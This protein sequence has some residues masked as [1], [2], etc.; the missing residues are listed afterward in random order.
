MSYARLIWGAIA[1]IWQGL[2]A[3][4]ALLGFLLFSTKP[5][6]GVITA[7][8][9]AISTVLVKQAILLLLP[10]STSHGSARFADYEDLV[11]AKLFA[12]K[13]II[14]GRKRGRMIRYKG[15]GHLLTFAPTRSGKGVGCV[16]PNLLS[17]SGSVVVTDIKGENIAIAGR[18]RES[19]GQVYELA[20]FKEAYNP[21][22]YN[23]FDFIRVGSSYEVDD[24][25][26]ISE[27]LVISERAE[28]NHWEREARTLITGLILYIMHEGNVLTQ[29]PSR[30]RE[31][32]M[33]DEEGFEL[34]IATMMAHEHPVISRIA[35]GFSQKAEKERSGVVS[36]AQGATE[37][38]E[39]PLLSKITSNSSFCLSELKEKTV[40]LFLV[41]P[42]EYLDTYRPYLRLMIGLCAATMTR[43]TTRPEHEV[44]FLLDELPAL[45]YMRPIEEGIGYLAGYKAK[46]WL[47]VQDLDQLQHTYP[48]A[49]SII[50]NCAVRQAFNV[51]DPQTARLLSEMM[52][53]TTIKLKSAGSTGKL[54]I[55]LM[56]GSYQS[57]IHEGSRE[58]M[59]P[60]EVMAMNKKLQLLFIQGIPPIKAKKIRY[61]DWSEWRFW[62]KY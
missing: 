27:M 47:F 54:P 59:T 48:K 23:P 56:S 41:I 32:L 30:L 34:Y 60:A 35:C 11:R 51:Q 29:N 38:F 21:T 42:P 43:Q 16:I 57:S 5:L 52:G 58:L 18:Y 8:I 20:P 55:R 36:T 33:A 31:I 46:L 22:C 62:R 12:R 45:G 6:L 49:R 19:L 25:R 17:W 4:M 2:P 28:P 37:V 13:G 44:L 50:A 7:S 9:W 40:S 10:P 3:L 39:S 14:L 24:T 61:F 15:D 53:T 1:L 26:L